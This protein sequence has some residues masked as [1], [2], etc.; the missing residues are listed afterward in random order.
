MD[1]IMVRTASILTLSTACLLFESCGG[2]GQSGAPTSS[3]GS[4]QQ[5][6]AVSMTADQ[7][8]I[9]A[10]QTVTLT[11]TAQSATQV[12][13]SNNVD[14]TTYTLPGTGGTQKV[15]PSQ[16][17]TYTATATGTSGQSVTATTQVTVTPAGSFQSVQHVVMLLQENRTFDTYF[18]MLNPFRKAN[19]L[20]VGDDGKEYDVDGIDDKLSTISNVNDQGQ[21]FQLF[22][23]SSSCLD[24]MS[25]AWLESYGDVSRNDFSTTRPILMNG[26]VHT[27]QGFANSCA[28]NID[29]RTGKSRCSGDFTDLAGERAMAYYQDT[30]VTGSPE[31]NYYY[32]MASQF[33]LSDRWFSPVSS[34][35][36]PNRIATYSGGTTQGLVRDPYRD[37]DLI[38][39]VTHQDA[40]NIGPLTAKTIFEELDGAQVPWKIYYSETLDG[41][42]ADGSACTPSGAPDKRP[43]TTFTLFGYG[44]KY[45]SGTNPDGSC[46]NGLQPGSSPGFCV[47]PNHI[48]PISQ[49]YTDVQNNTL[50]AF[51][52]IEAEYGITDEHPGS[53]Q[54]V[55]NGQKQ[56]ASLIN[57]L[58]QSPS[59]SSSVF[60]LAYDEGGGPYDHVPPIPGHSN[61]NTTD[62]NKTTDYPDIS[63]IAVNADDFKPCQPPP[64]TNPD[65]ANQWVPTQNCDLKPDTAGNPPGA[66]PEPGVNPTDAPAQQG[67]AAQLGFRVPNMIISPFTKRHY[68]G[69]APMDH[70]AV[71][72]FVEARFLPQGSPNLTPRVAAQPDLMDF[73][74]FAKI[75]WAT[76]PTGTPQPPDVGSSC[77]PETMH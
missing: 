17:V 74:D 27:A 70:T 54:S 44:G 38:D 19:N 53:G 60:F 10:G 24:D 28:T 41:C 35:S 16:N 56:A 33:A 20:S 77:H 73:F 49:Y 13:I 62:P 7:T 66:I 29:P 6:V 75:P 50:P 25:S 34:K 1:K 64:S 15:T 61:D 48:A 55:L 40:H 26:F 65:F 58:M 46:P 67:F 36:T 3:G 2:I 47:D 68:V 32:Y 51:A 11:V 8:T 39:P 5:Q 42:P 43:S 23:T 9:T 63:G 31:L 69:H 22:H 71:L 30:S 59:W 72:K 14:A 4:Q 21:A 12:T 57:A 37:D 52:Y 18:G 45:I 76:P